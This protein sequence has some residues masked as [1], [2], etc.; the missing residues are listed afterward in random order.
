MRIGFSTA[1]INNPSEDYINTLLDIAQSECSAIEFNDR[2]EEYSQE[3]S[4][5]F[6]DIA[7]SYDYRSIH[8][9]VLLSFEESRT[10]IDYWLK[11]ADKIDAHSFT[12]H[13]TNM[14]S[15]DWLNQAF[16]ERLALENMD[17]RKDYGKSVKDMVHALNIVEGAGWIYDLNHVY[18][19]DESMSLADDFMK[20]LEKRLRHYHISGFGDD[21]LPHTSLFT[22]KQDEIIKKLTRTDKPIIIES[23]GVEDINNWRKE[24]DYISSRLK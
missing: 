11:F 17:W 7:K 15:F 21:N 4:Q 24:L 18:T 3:P 10:A 12:L 19:N 13:P 6:I 16:D 8:L 5:I 9:P 1:I 2:I 20:A 23:F 14:Q 22:T